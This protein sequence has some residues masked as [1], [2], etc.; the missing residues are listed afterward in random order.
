MK[1]CYPVANQLELS[2]KTLKKEELYE[3]AKLYFYLHSSK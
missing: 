3:A 1:L 2:A